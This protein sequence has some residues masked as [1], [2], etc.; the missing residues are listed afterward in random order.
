M[1][2]VPW[3]R[4]AAA[5]ATAATMLLLLSVAATET[6]DGG[7]SDGGSDGG[8]IATDGGNEWVECWYC[9]PKK[10]CPLPWTEEGTDKLNCSGS[11]MKFDGWTEKENHRVMMRDCGYFKAEECS[12]DE[13]LFDGVTKGRLCHCMTDNCNGVDEIRS[14]FTVVLVSAV[15][16]L[17]VLW[18]QM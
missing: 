7:G 11:C 18:S 1:A 5:A 13:T 2:A 17:F 3:T 4:S 8:G 15:V 14:S 12:E 16:V 6:A 9:G 10:E